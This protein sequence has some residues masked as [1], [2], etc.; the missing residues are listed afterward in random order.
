[1]AIRMRINDGPFAGREGKWVTS[2]KISERLDRELRSNVALQVNPTDTSDEFEVRGR[3]ELHL[4][5]LIETMRREGYELCVSRP[6]VI[7]KEDE[8][9]KKLEPFENLLINCESPYAGAI[10]EKL[11]RRGGEMTAMRDAGEGRTAMEFMIPTRSLIG[12]RSEMLTDTR[13]TG[14]MA[15]TFA[16]YGPYQGARK[17]RARGVLIALETGE[18]S[19]YSLN[20]LQDRGTLFIGGQVPVYGGM[21]IG[22]HCRDTDLVVNPTIGRKLT[23]VRTTGHEEKM[24]LTPATIFS[25][26]ESLAFI[27]DDELLEVTPNSLRLRKRVLDHNMRKRIEKSAASA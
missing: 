18:S 7:L 27:S 14:V 6:R 1:M 12:Y 11:G 9:G 23:N 22:E 13:G 8:D 15:S 10:I 2:R 4:S 16:H 17:S 21:I 19:A 5:V 25:L 20:R 26:E 3:G 24:V